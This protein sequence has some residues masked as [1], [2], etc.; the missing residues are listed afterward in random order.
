MILRRHL[1]ATDLLDVLDDHVH[2]PVSRL[3]IQETKIP[4]KIYS[5]N[6]LFS[7][8]LVMQDT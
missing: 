8:L 1:T 6:Q 4:R 7:K 2:A 5:I 3:M